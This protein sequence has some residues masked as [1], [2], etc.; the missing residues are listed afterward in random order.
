L[1]KNINYLAEKHTGLHT[2]IGKPIEHLSNGYD[3]S[4]QSP[5]YSTGIG[6][7]I[8]AIKQQKE[9]AIPN[10][11]ENTEDAGEEMTTEAGGKKWRDKILESIKTI[12][13]PVQ[14][15]EF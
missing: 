11:P 10:A 4:I 7:L 2:R 15:S 3:D 8:Y 9:I 1:L 6:L 12:F 13:E 14:D 5:I